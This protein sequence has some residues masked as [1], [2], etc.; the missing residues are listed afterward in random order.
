M[1]NAKAGLPSGITAKVNS[2]VDPIIIKLLYDASK[3]GVKINL[4]V[5][6]ICC[7]VPGI[8]DISENIRVISIVGQLLEHSRIFKF[9][10]AGNPIIYMGSADWMPRNLNRRVELIFPIEDPDLKERTFDMLNLML[11]DNTNARVEQSDTTYVSVDKRGKKIISSQRIFS[12]MAQ[13]ALK[14]KKDFHRNDLFR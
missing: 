10:S 1:Q 7:L 2:L 5:R 13:K 8:K 11:K 3:A 14:D 9:E 12:Q 6:G 4:I